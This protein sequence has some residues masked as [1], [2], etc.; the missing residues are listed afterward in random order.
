MVKV[1]DPL[2]RGTRDRRHGLALPRAAAQQWLIL[3][4]IWLVA[5]IAGADWQ[6]IRMQREAAIENFLVGQTNLTNGMGAQTS[7]TLGMMDKA[8]RDIAVALGTNDFQASEGMQARLRS[9]GT[10]ALLEAS[11]KPL[12]GTLSLTVVDTNGQTANESG[13]WP[14]ADGTVAKDLLQQEV[15]R[16]FRSGPG[17]QI[18]IGPPRLAPASGIW[19]VLLAR[20]LNEAAGRFAGWVV[21]EISLADLEDFYHLAMPIHRTISLIRPDGTIVLRYPHG[22]SV[23]GWKMP[24]GSPF[25]AAAAKG[26]RYFETDLLNATPVIA[27]SRPLPGLPLIVETLVSMDEVLAGWRAERHWMILGGVATCAGVIALIYLFA[28]QLRRLAERNCQ[29]DKVRRQLDVA[30]SNVSQG[31]C[32]FD[33]D[34]KLIVCNRRLGE[35]YGLPVAKMCP[36]AGFAEMVDALFSVNAPS[37]VTKLELLMSRERMEHTGEPRDAI[38]EFPDGRAIDVH[39]RPLPDGGW[40]ATHEDITER[41]RSEAQISFLARHDALTGLPNRSVLAERIELAR[42]GAGRSIGFALLFLDLDRFKI[43]N[44]TLGHA[45][46][47]ELLKQVAERLRGSVR[48]GDTVVRLGGDEFV[49]LQSTLKTPQAAATLAERII[50]AI[51]A[52]YVIAGNEVLIGVSIGI[53]IATDELSKSHDFLK[54]ADRAMYSAKSEGRGVYRFF[55]PAMDAQVQERHLMERDLRHALERCEFVLHY[56]AIVDGKSGLTHGFEALLRWNH[57]GLGVVGPADF[58]PIAEETGLIN[59]IGEWVVRQACRDAA[60]W[61]DGLYVSVN[62]SAV[63]FRAPDLV[64]VVR[65]ALAAAALPA[66][67]LELEVTESVLLHNNTHN[68]AMMHAFHASGISIT[69]D[70]FGTGYSSLGYLRQFP[71]QRI[72]IDRSF[73][74]DIA[75]DRDAAAIVRA[76]LGLCRDLGIKTT[77]EGVETAG[78]VAV[79][80][81]GGAT[82]MQGFLFSR[83]KPASM[84]GPMLSGASLIS[85]NTV[86]AVSAIAQAS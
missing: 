70:D 13:I 84:L 15:F 62:L 78:Q 17:A 55:E 59:Q 48:D 52:P 14:P 5:G 43:V 41:R 49:V 10:F 71:F 75:T 54:N 61:P 22:S 38:Y 42:A 82:D 76:I 26:G 60:R 81:E 34:H 46:G 63:Q 44:D 8:L 58:I 7:R 74:K 47:D 11:L 65:D 68:L 12:T 86:N 67:R 73:V 35:I 28:A 39:E 85:S 77:A 33:G 72:K 27:V 69:M 19:S 18:A 29:L 21:A 56:Q 2:N 66:E 51:G 24:A 16:R 25:Y 80:R 36:G 57:P 83:P 31:I 6:S 37:N 30:I 20:R 64:A 53:E 23:A 3:L 4:G 45:A 9:R 40:V 32:F 50:A 1:F 79:L